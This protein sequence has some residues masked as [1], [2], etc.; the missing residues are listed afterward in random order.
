MKNQEC[1]K[2]KPTAMVCFCYRKRHCDLVDAYER[3]GSLK[4]LEQELNIGRACG[5]CKVVLESLFGE[6]SSDINAME[7]GATGHLSC[8]Q[9]GSRIMKGFVIS[10]DELDTKI[11]SSNAVAPQL[12]D[13][14]S[15]AQLEYLIIGPNGVPVIHQSQL[16]KTNE[17][18]LLD[19]AELDLPKPFFGMFHLVFDRSNFGASRFNMYWYNDDGITS[20]HENAASGRPD[21]FLPF[22]VDEKFLKGPNKVHLA[23]MNPNDEIVRLSLRAFDVDANNEIEWEADLNANGSTWIDASEHLFPKL[24]KKVDKARVSL[25]IRSTNQNIHKSLSTYFFLHN[26]NTNTWSANHL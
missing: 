22:L 5:G 15:S 18:F 7:S 19:T 26:R 10:T 8:V 25:H 14:D 16:V 4:A 3:L 11:Y 2:A 6:Q 1:E 9:P 24:L 20:T 21:V 23:I 17:T 12:G 13:C